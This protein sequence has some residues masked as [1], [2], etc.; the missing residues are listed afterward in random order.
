M[1]NLTMTLKQQVFCQQKLHRW[2]SEE[3]TWISLWENTGQK[4]LIQRSWVHRNLQDVFAHNS[5]Q[6]RSKYFELS[7]SASSEN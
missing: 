7:F 6:M 5:I 4:S 1:E 2:R 3:H